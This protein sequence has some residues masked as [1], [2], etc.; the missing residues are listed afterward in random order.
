VSANRAAYVRNEDPH[1]GFN[2]YSTGRIEQG[3]QRDPSFRFVNATAPFVNIS[4][5]RHLEA[6]FGN[7]IRL[8][9]PQFGQPKRPFID[10][11]TPEMAALWAGKLNPNLF[12]PC[13]RQDDSS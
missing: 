6:N 8:A 9:F 11:L 4:S 1:P 10:N 13:R 12:A 2:R 3:H 7:T 5:V